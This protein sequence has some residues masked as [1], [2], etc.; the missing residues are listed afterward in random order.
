MTNEPPNSSPENREPSPEENLPPEASGDR[1]YRWRRPAIIGLGILGLAG[2]GAYVGVRVL[3]IRY[4]PELVETQLQQITKRDVRVGKVTYLSPFLTRLNIGKTTILPGKEATAGEKPRDRAEIEIPEIQIGFNPLPL[5]SKKL[6]LEIAF[7]NPKVSAVQDKA[8]NW[9]YLELDLPEGGELPID[10]QSNIRIKDGEIVLVPYGAKSKFELGLNSLVRLRDKNK[11]VRYDADVKVGKGKLEVKGETLVDTI[12]TKAIARMQ[13][14]SLTEINPFLAEFPVKVD[15]GII[16]GN[17]NVNLP[18][19]KD[20]KSSEVRGVL[21]LKDV[22]VT[23]DALAESLTSKGLL[24]FQ[25]QSVRIDE[26]RSQLGDLVAVVTGTAGLKS[27]LDVKVNV[28]EVAIASLLELVPAEVP[29]AVAGT[30]KANVN[31]TGE[32]DD[33]KVSGTLKNGG[34]LQVDR[35]AT[36]QEYRTEIAELVANF[37]G[38]LSQAKLDELR[39]IP[40][41]GGEVIA[42]G[43]VG[44]E[45]LQLDFEADALLPVDAL[46]QPY[47]IPA[48]IRVGNLLA[49]VEVE[50][51]AND[52]NIRASWQLPGAEVAS[53]LPI[54]GSG[55]AVLEGQDFFLEDTVLQIGEGSIAATGR[56]N[57]EEKTWE[58]EITS[59]SLPLDR[60]LP[61]QIAPLNVT[62]SGRLD[63]FDPD[64]LQ[65]DTQIG[66]DLGGGRVESN[67]SFDRGNLGA[68]GTISQVQLDA[69]GVPVPIT[70]QDGR[71]LL[72]GRLDAW[73]ANAVRATANLDLTVNGGNVAATAQLNSGSLDVSANAQQIPVNNLIPNLPIS[74]ALLDSQF[75][76]QSDINFL[77]SAVQSQ[78][79]SGLNGTVNARLAVNEGTVETTARLAGNNLKLV[80]NAG[81]IGVNYLA[82]DLPV[83]VTLRDSTTTLD[84][85]VATLINAAQTQDFSQITARSNVQLG[86]NEGTVN[87]DVTVRN[88]AINLL[89]N[90]SQVSLNSIVP[91]LPVSATLIDSRVNVNASVATLLDAAKTQDVT[92]INADVTAQL[93]VNGGTVNTD[94]KLR[95]GAVDL[96]ANASQVS[97]NSIV[98]N[99]PA[100]VALIDST[101]NLSASTNTLLAAA[102]T[103]DF[104]AINARANARLAVNEGT[105]NT[106]VVANAGQLDIAATTTQF[107]L[108]EIA[109]AIP[110]T[111]T[112]F[113]SEI[114]ATTGINALVSAAQTQDF[115]QLDP[116]ASA[117]V[118]LGVAD[119]IVNTT[120]NLNNGQWQTAM[121]ANQLNTIAL[122][123]ATGQ[124][125]PPNT[126][127]PPLNTQVDLAGTLD[128][129]LAL[130]TIPVEVNNVALQLGQ[131][132][133]S[134]NGSIVLANPTATLDI[135]NVN[136]K[137]ATRYNTQTLPLETLIAAASFGQASLPDHVSIDGA[138]AFDGRIRG[139]NLISN[140]LAPGNVNLT[141]DLALNNFQF[142]DI[143]FEP[144]LVGDVI[145]NSGEEIA[146]NLRG[147]RDVIAAR[148][149]PCT[150]G[151]ACLAPYLPTSFEL[152]Q[153]EIP[154]LARGQRRGDV[155][156]VEL[157]NFDLALLNIAPATQAGIQGTVGG[158]AS[159][160]VAV[161]LLTLETEGRAQLLNPFLGYLQAD[162]FT[163]EFS[164]KNGVARLENSRFQLGESLYQADASIAFDIDKLLAGNFDLAASPI[165][166]RITVADG[167]VQDLLTA[168]QF[169]TIEDLQRGISS[170]VYLS[171]EDLDLPSVGLP[172]RSLF[173]Q[174]SLF[175]QINYLLQ[176]RVAEL[177]TASIP[178]QLDIAGLYDA[179]VTFGGT[180]GN[181]N[182]NFD[183]Q[184][185]NWLW[186]TQ[187]D[188]VVVGETVSRQTRQVIEIDRIDVR[189]T[190]ENQTVTVNPALVEVE[191][192]VAYFAGQASPTAQSGQL[193]VENLSLDAI[194]NFAAIPEGAQGNINLLANLGGTRGNPQ[195]RGEVNFVDASWQGKP[196][197]AFVGSFNYDTDEDKFVFASVLPEYVE[198]T[199]E[200]P[201]PPIPQENDVVTLEAKV[202][203]EATQFLPLFTNGQIEWMGGEVRLDLDARALLDLEGN[204]VS[205]LLRTLN[206]H[207]AVRLADATL[208][209]PY[210]KEALT[211]DG[212]MAFNFNRICVADPQWIST[213]FDGEGLDVAEDAN[214]GGELPLLCPSELDEGVIAGNPT[215]ILVGNFGGSTLMVTGDLPTLLTE[216]VE[217]PL[218]VAINGEDGGE[219]DIKG[220]FRGEVA[221]RVQVTGTAIMPVIGGNIAVAEGRAIVP[222][223]GGNSDATLVA[224]E[225]PQTETTPLIV[226]EFDNFTLEI[227]DDF[228]VVK[229]PI[230]DVRV[231]GGVTVN[232]P[233]F[234]L[235]PEGK[236]QLTRG[237]IRLFD[238]AGIEGGF[239][240]SFNNR[241]FV[242][243]DYPQTVEFFPEQGLLNPTLNL[244]LGTIVFEDRRSRLRDRTETEVPAPEVIPT[245]RPEQIKILVNVQGTAQ[246]LIASIAETNDFSSGAV[247]LTSIPQRSD[248]EIVGLLGN[249][250]LTSFEEIAQLQ[251]DELVQFALLRF[252]VQPYADN[253]LFD[254]E[255]FVSNWGQKVGLR[256]LRVFPIGQVEAVYDLTEDSSLTTIYD[257][258]FD[259]IQFRYDLRF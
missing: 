204:M 125:I 41:A 199:A 30:L 219:L 97:L 45:D 232:G 120:A 220:L 106:N 248:S 182:A 38:N 102:R 91:D 142:N 25:G 67:A 190:L 180:V 79:F 238:V 36:P 89:A 202:G 128:S 228:S 103:Q 157:E 42:R 31:I 63:D 163:G 153:G 188:E 152:R 123:S 236:F 181:P 80:A 127:L 62:A 217:N 51:T 167:R 118:R 225:S 224:T 226:P 84:T 154:I 249:S 119:G 131:E 136:L 252:V 201:Y 196:L 70:L 53:T 168:A 206:A 88:G 114:N 211:L 65:A 35:E 130:Q 197:D 20:W 3:V 141:G 242:T 185:E 44:L 246:Q 247:T 243:R 184:A 151:E 33:P 74:V 95:S 47:G 213:V 209:T 60:F 187:P 159:A 90:A 198:I 160:E 24:Q 113:N 189:G 6:P 5:V 28:P 138:I 240:G 52:P 177:E 11:R 59:A 162:N 235:Q 258:E 69:L 116:T 55:E 108:N 110:L 57:L 8:G 171:A 250:L 148:L 230:L 72:T 173:A 140:P 229:S 121:D 49:Q 205:K 259:A 194:G 257:Y 207:G 183:F 155:L 165:Q 71:L 256:D 56:G 82:P 75:N 29:V 9:V 251:G 254:I 186:T 237:V 215:P 164:Y 112:V 17:L 2:V 94:T 15:R 81:E 150:R 203:T 39:L 174:L 146:L 86:V 134:T 26:L 126:N 158:T 192:A 96:L 156:N 12:A 135:A 255:D 161:N 117:R 21:Q 191:G 139:R 216:A 37:S 222:T 40:A 92:G 245:V 50:G 85:S 4:L 212:A 208:E 144:R 175:A 34:I 64:S 1:L 231:R 227:G 93:D 172:N 176:Q 73:D 234:D 221:G 200:V 27:G 87:A 7:V 253:I 195:L 99:L 46:A 58:A 83:S 210:V 68:S 133:F 122:L 241:F 214:S 115:S 129:L 147:N 66:A 109:P 10:I 145:V 19:L 124:K 98:P 132:F 169:F 43:E 32:I 143:A 179:E 18:S 77:I 100:N 149:E 166:G 239:N 137:V 104:S 223:V 178:T 61:V 76:F 13:N 170:P 78:D 48:D 14:L 111:V 233:L 23:A 22:E 193:R 101:L 105:V 107:S 16:E 244:Q 54:S 218:T